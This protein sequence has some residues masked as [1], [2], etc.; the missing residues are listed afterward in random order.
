MAE[1]KFGGSRYL[2]M[3]AAYW[4]AVAAFIGIAHRLWPG[5]AESAPFIVSVVLGVSIAG[6]VIVYIFRPK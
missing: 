5:L 1:K 3:G 4:I 6:F 2:M